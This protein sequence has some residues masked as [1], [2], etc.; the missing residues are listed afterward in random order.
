MEVVASAAPFCMG[1]LAGGKGG[2]D[3]SQSWYVAAVIYL[4]LDDIWK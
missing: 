4:Y 1:W 2:D 3:D